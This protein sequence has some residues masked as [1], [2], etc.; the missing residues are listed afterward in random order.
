MRADT[1][2]TPFVIGLGSPYI[3]AA[4][5]PDVANLA[6]HC[7]SRLD[8]PCAAI[9][10]DGPFFRPCPRCQPDLTPYLPFDQFIGQIVA[11]YARTRNDPQR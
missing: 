3:H 4:A 10:T 9:V 2:S 6:E 5:C 11:R 7:V 1:H 8:G